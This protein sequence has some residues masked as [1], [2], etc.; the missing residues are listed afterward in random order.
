M[1]V[2]MSPVLVLIGQFCRDVIGRQNEKNVSTIWK[3]SL[4]KRM[5]I[6][7]VADW[8]RKIA[9]LFLFSQSLLMLF[10]EEIH[11]D[12]QNIVLILPDTVYG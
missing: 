11:C 2:F 8:I 7:Q 1:M 10:L 9:D 5:F 4:E 6:C 3:Q 12:Q